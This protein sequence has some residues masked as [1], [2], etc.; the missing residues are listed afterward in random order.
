MNLEFASIKSVKKNIH[1]DSHKEET[2][3]NGLN[4]SSD[5]QEIKCE[6]SVEDFT[7]FSWPLIYP[8][9]LLNSCLLKNSSF[10]LLKQK[11]I[12]FYRKQEIICFVY[13]FFLFHSLSFCSFLFVQHSSLYFFSLNF[14]IGL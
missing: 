8:L 10:L 13:P 4:Q 2:F 11:I 12:Q 7:V 9:T 3:S 5:L 14:N 6:L 1:E